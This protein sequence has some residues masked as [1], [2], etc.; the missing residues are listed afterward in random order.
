MKDHISVTVTQCF[1][2]FD[3]LLEREIPDYP[4]TQKFDY[5]PLQNRS[6]FL[7]YSIEVLSFP[8]Q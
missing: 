3:L 4:G 2:I 1:V 8:K 5:G 7:K 6:L